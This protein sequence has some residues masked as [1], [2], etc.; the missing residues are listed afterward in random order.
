MN[1]PFLNCDVT[2][3]FYDRLV[4]MPCNCFFILAT[5]QTVCKKSL[6]YLLLRRL[7]C[8]SL[9][10]C[11]CAFPLNLSLAL[12]LF[13]LLSAIFLLRIWLCFLLFF[14]SYYRWQRRLTRSVSPSC[15]PDS[16]QGRQSSSLFSCPLLLLQREPSWKVI[17]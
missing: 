14:I 5:F 9:T 11:F 16:R 12:F 3:G 17:L 15:P 13:L 4:D 2:V 1:Q 6:S 7:E 8:K 10:R